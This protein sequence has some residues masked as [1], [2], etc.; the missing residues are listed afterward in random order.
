MGIRSGATPC[1]RTQTIMTSSFLNF[2]ADIS[3]WRE[4]GHF[5]LALTEKENSSGILASVRRLA[6]ALERTDKVLVEA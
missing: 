5:Y 3:N 2:N 4:L 6:D 1:G